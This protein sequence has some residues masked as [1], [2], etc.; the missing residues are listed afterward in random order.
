LSFARAV[1][2]DVRLV[3]CRRKHIGARPHPPRAAGGGR[4]RDWPL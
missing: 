3:D 1:I 4:E 2:N